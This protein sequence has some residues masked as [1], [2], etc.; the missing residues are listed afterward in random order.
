[1][2]PPHPG[3]CVFVPGSGMCRGGRAF[4]KLRQAQVRTLAYGKPRTE[5][6]V[7]TYRRSPWRPVLC[8]TRT[9]CPVYRPPRYLKKTKKLSSLFLQ[10]LRALRMCF[11]VLASHPVKRAGRR[12]C[13]CR[14]ITAREA[15]TYTGWLS[16]RSQTPS[17]CFWV[18]NFR[19][20]LSASVSASLSVSLYLW[21]GF[22]Q[23]A[24]CQQPHIT[25]VQARV[26][27]RA[28]AW[29]MWSDG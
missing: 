3:P 1:M 2:T 22:R 24:L 25:P 8:F 20:T 9:F 28:P 17:Q 16:K 5:A 4:S 14:T 13:L 18:S 11:P 15:G 7:T 12:L 26:R 23:A 19:P 27:W 6:C 29:L 10:F 21:A